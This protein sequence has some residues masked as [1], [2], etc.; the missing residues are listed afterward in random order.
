ME[1]LLAIFAA[2]ADPTR[3][4]IF[5]LV[6]DMQ[7]SMGE[8]A[9]ILGQSQ[10]R[11]S[12]HVRLLAEAGLVRR[13]K[14]GAWV[15]VDIEDQQLAEAADTIIATAAPDDEL[16]APERARL[17]EVRAERERALDIWFA[18]KAGEW[19]L[20]SRLG[21][22]E[23]EV[24]EAL[25]ATALAEP[26]GRLLDIG[27][28][29]GTML[30]QLAEH[31]SAAVGIDRSAEMLRLARGKLSPQGRQI[32]E[33]LPADMRNLPFAD[34][35]FDLVTLVQ[36][37]H[38]ADDPAAVVDEAARVLAPGGRMLI[39]EFAPHDHEEL[40]A[41]FH[42]ARLGFEEETVL[43]WMRAAG[44]TARVVSRHPGTRLQVHITEGKKLLIHRN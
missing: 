35:S 2:L 31:A 16:I 41:R 24:E 3:L 8:L 17:A 27:T 5:M 22:Q 33:L 21:G 32:A 30:A 20:V 12:R 26:V 13:R 23:P 25:A 39:A 1:R 10:P 11:V 18:E 37:L 14:E 4:R 9:D 40:R 28:G 6:R 38:F 19:D 7:L 34:A 15:F 42:H 29:T 44:L 36:V 43:G